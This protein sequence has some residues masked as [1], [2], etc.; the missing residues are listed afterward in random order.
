[1]PKIPLSLLLLLVQITMGGKIDWQLPH[2]LLSDFPYYERAPHRSHGQNILARLFLVWKQ[3]KTEG[4]RSLRYDG[5]QGCHMCPVFSPWAAVSVH[6]LPSRS[7]PAWMRTSQPNN[8]PDP[9]GDGQ[10][11]R[12]CNIPGGPQLQNRHGKEPVSIADGQQTQYW[13]RNELQF[14]L[15]QGPTH[16]SKRSPRQLPQKIW[17]RSHKFPSHLQ[18]G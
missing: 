17:R 6:K 2:P 16:H 12:R 7:S 15:S 8:P 9:R 11:R 5:Q 4:W 1:M 13:G 14:S 3:R 18:A 10:E